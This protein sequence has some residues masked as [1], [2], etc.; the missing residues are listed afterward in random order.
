MT[1]VV[2][3]LKTFGFPVA[4]AIYL[5]YERRSVMKE[6][7]T[8]VEANTAATVALYTLIKEQIKKD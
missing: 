2:E 6:L 8:A 3:L 5:L 7:Q 1:E 4:V